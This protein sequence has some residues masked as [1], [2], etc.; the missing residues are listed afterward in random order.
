MIFYCDVFLLQS[1]QKKSIFPFVSLIFNELVPPVLLIFFLSFFCI[2]K[3]LCGLF[4]TPQMACL[5]WR[6]GYEIQM[7]SLWYLATF[8]VSEIRTAWL[9]G[10]AWHTHGGEDAVT[11]REITIPCKRAAWT[12]RGQEPSHTHAHTHAYAFCFITKN[13]TVIP[14]SYWEKGII[15]LK[16]V[17]KTCMIPKRLHL[18]IFCPQLTRIL[19]NIPFVAVHV[20]MCLLV[21]RPAEAT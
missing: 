12:K 11:V 15:K 6:P 5:R 8:W 3:Y 9:E 10:A 20:L 18:H 19:K 14:Y 1:A 13:G 7:G 16:L 17:M 2:V 4:V 21:Q